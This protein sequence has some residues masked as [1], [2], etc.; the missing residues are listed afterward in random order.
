MI[1]DRNPEGSGINYLYAARQTVEDIYEYEQEQ[2]EL[3]R[4]TFLSRL[5]VYLRLR[6]M[7]LGIQR[8]A[9][10]L[11]K[12]RIGLLRASNYVPEI[13]NAIRKRTGLS[14]SG[15]FAAMY[16]LLGGDYM[17]ENP[18]TTAGIYMGLNI[19]N[20]DKWIRNPATTAASAATTTSA[21]N[22]AT[23]P[24]TKIPLR[25]RVRNIISSTSRMTRA[26]LQR[27]IKTLT[28][29]ATRQARILGS[30]AA[31]VFSGSLA[32]SVAASS[33]LIPVVVKNIG[34]VIDM[35]EKLR[36]MSYMDFGDGK[37]Y[38]SAAGR[39]E[40]D[41]ALEAIANANLNARSFM[42]N[43]AQFYHGR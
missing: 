34:R 8:M 37:R 39:S 1:F 43:E 42:G 41:R 38:L 19:F 23:P 14:P 11:D 25:D 10:P 36:D 22:T 33:L 31:G 15:K 9:N 2:R 20:S 32:A 5:T 35:S 30:G 29:T 28:G 17:A 27:Q 3:D 4:S 6:A 7:Q 12:N 16:L 26:D 21:V 18:F 24:V 13:V 40:R